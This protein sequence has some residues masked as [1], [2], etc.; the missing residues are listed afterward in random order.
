MGSRCPAWQLPGKDGELARREAPWPLCAQQPRF[1]PPPHPKLQ[2][3][4]MPLSHTAAP[5]RTAPTSLTG[6]QNEDTPLLAPGC[7]CGLG[8]LGSWWLS[9][10]CLPSPLFSPP[11]KQSIDSAL[12]D[13]WERELGH[14]YK[15]ASRGCSGSLGWAAVVVSGTAVCLCCHSSSCCLALWHSSALKASPTTGKEMTLGSSCGDTGLLRA[16]AV[17]SAA[18][19][20]EGFWC[21]VSPE[22][23]SLL[24]WGKA[25]GEQAGF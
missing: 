21:G 24:T 2:S 5:L 19:W 11:S 25:G 20:T 4:P 23:K 16:L 3:T 1:P 18:V 8:S 13:W 22:A 10:V 15:E 17:L 14:T 9:G 7:P 6:S 12:V